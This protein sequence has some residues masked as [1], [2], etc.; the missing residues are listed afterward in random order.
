[1]K[2]IRY[3][4]LAFAGAIVI[5]LLAGAPRDSAAYAR[6][7]G[8]GHGQV[9]KKAVKKAPGQMKRVT[10]TQPTCWWSQAKRPFK[11]AEGCPGGIFI[12]EIQR[13]GQRCDQQEEQ[14]QQ[15]HQMPLFQSWKGG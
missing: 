9:K 14:S 2:S 7:H 6:Q 12:A 8:Y 13:I 10:K 5:A 11:Q 4:S 1:M 15:P 3:A